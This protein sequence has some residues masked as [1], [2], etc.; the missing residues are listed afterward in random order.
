MADIWDNKVPILITVLLAAI[1]AF[2]SAR[3]GMADVVKDNALQDQR[4]E[5]HE[6]TIANIAKDNTKQHAAI[7][8]DLGELKLQVTTLTA[9]VRFLSKGRVGSP[10]TLPEV[11]DKGI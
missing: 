1:A 11:L 8:K 10:L 7:I 2:G 6:N 4:L 3:W 5:Q 9:E